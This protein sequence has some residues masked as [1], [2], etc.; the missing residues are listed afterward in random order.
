[1]RKIIINLLLSAAMLYLISWIFPGIVMRSFGTAIVAALVL[2]LVNAFIKPIICLLSLPLTILTLGLFS[3]VINALMLLL[4]SSLMGGRFY[5]D[6]F[7]TAF[8]A[9]ILLSLLNTF[10]IKDQE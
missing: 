1:M 3:L 6:G 10:F 5:I 8:L 7:A 2:G 9:A 4:A